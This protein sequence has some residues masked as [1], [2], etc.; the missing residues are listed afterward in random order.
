M[1]D[2]LITEYKNTDQYKIRFDFKFTGIWTALFVET[3]IY[4]LAVFSLRET[5]KALY[6]SDDLVYSLSKTG[7]FL[8]GITVQK[9]YH[10]LINSIFNGG[11]VAGRILIGQLPTK[12]PMLLFDNILQYRVLVLILICINIWLFGKCVYQWTNSYKIKWTLMLITPLMFQIYSN[13]IH[14]PIL[15]FYGLMQ[16][17]FITLYASMYFFWRYCVEH[18]IFFL[19]I[20]GVFYL[21]GLVTYEVAFTFIPIFILLA[22]LSSR[23]MKKTA[24]KSWLH[25]VLFIFFLAINYLIS[26]SKS[27]GGITVNLNLSKIAR[28]TLDQISASFPL[29]NFWD[30][31]W[32]QTKSIIPKLFSISNIALGDIITVVLFLVVLYIIYK[33]VEVKARF[34]YTG[35]L[36]LGGIG[37]IIIIFPAILIGLSSKYQNEVG[38]GRGH[39]PVYIQ[40]YGLMVFLGAIYCFI[41]EA[42]KRFD[43]R[44]FV[45]G[46]I[47]IGLIIISVF[48]LLTNQQYGRAAINN[49]NTRFYNPML[50]LQYSIQDD[51]LDGIGD[52]ALIIN[53]QSVPY[54]IV[55][56]SEY[57]TLFYINYSQKSLKNVVYV[58]DYLNQLISTYV[59]KGKER[60][61]IDMPVT[62]P[63]YIV[64]TN[65][66]IDN[67]AVFLGEVKDMTIDL[68]N[69]LIIKCEINKLR[70]YTMNSLNAKYISLYHS[71]SAKTNIHQYY[72]LDNNIVRNGNYGRLYE[73]N[74][75]DGLIDFNSVS[76][77]ND[78][79][80]INSNLYTVVGQPVYVEFSQPINLG[81]NLFNPR[82]FVSGW[83]SQ[84]DWGRWSE[85]TQSTLLM[86]I[87]SIL[88]SD[89][90][91][92]FTS[93][94]FAPI[95]NLSFSISVNDIY[96]D[97]FSLH[98]G[99]QQFSVIVPMGNI[100]NNDGNLKLLFDIDNPISPKQAGGSDDSRILGIG[101]IS[102]LIE[103]VK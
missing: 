98:N 91:L 84:E 103:E 68:S 44:K 26:P 39:I 45:S 59:N 61:I 77:V 4:L 23:S 82:I 16:L 73:Y 21:W 38:F 17:V 55:S 69:R 86:K 65:K 10:L 79:D 8:G 66:N 12:L 50:A 28:A 51:I 53:T 34:D 1:S 88:D 99:M 95:E 31:N 2:R 49:I 94:I 74:F 67:G 62:Q 83:S 11:P 63:T 87:R 40:Y 24:L 33:L 36:I 81:I 85:G 35:M 92:T 58:D 14:H 96:I 22:Y 47:N 43:T 70:V 97:H 42:L 5:L 25:I 71:T 6:S 3:L 90:R 30:S 80:Y 101:L 32:A 41:Q 57:S 13:Y 15:N 75:D 78:L 102:I 54:R 29:S 7:D 56:D 89:A 76:L 20:S 64:R 72:I 27:Y 48:I 9:L 52:N 46:I 19:I 93:I 18:K 100:L 37:M 60:G